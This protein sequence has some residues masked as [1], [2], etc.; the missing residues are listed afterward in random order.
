MVKV[1]GVGGKGRNL[2][3]DLEF[4]LPRV[5]GLNPE[6]DPEDSDGAGEDRMK[7][8]EVGKARDCPSTPDCTSWTASANRD[9]S[10]SSV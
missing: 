10:S 1:A 7:E 5:E 3:W 2:L 4:S 6:S 8:T 9:T